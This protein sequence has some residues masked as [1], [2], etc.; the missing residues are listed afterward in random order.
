MHSFD[1][2]ASNKTLKNIKKFTKISK[3]AYSKI[4]IVIVGT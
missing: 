3:R 2:F 4:K 1:S